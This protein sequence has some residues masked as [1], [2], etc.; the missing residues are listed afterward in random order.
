MDIQHRPPRPWLVTVVGGWLSTPTAPGAPR[1]QETELNEDVALVGGQ[2]A[3]ATINE[4]GVR[5][6]IAACPVLST[7]SWPRSTTATGWWL[8]DPAQRSG[9]PVW[10]ATSTAGKYPNGNRLMGCIAE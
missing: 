5:A 3:D 4:V 9:E 6:A 2:R 8:S 1:P 10:G 7:V